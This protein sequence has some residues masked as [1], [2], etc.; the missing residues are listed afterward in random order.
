LE[1]QKKL[2]RFSGWGSVYQIFE[3]WKYY[4]KERKTWYEL[5]EELRKLLTEKEYNAAA[6]ATQN[7]HYTSP[8][9][10]KEMWTAL[11][12]FGFS[13]GRI[14]EPALGV[15]HFFGLMPEAAKSKL[16]GIELDRITGKVAKYLYPEANVYVQG[17]EDTAL[18]D[19]FFDIAISNVPF[20]DIQIADN[21]YPR[22]LTNKIHNYFFVKAL[23]KV[24]PGGLIM[25][26]TSTGTMDA[27]TNHDV[28]KYLAGKADFI[29]AV[30]LPG[31]TFRGIAKTD[32]T[33]DIIV[34]KKRAEGQGAVRGS[35]DR[36]QGKRSG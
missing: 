17:F 6:R 23:D 14:L 32:V 20:G 27:R 9:V 10:I 36:K 11:G 3:P 8:E 7:A 31:S 5:N 2:V 29:G 1:E 18:P 15:G 21:S 12:R 35:V 33:T 25:F 28:R 22:Y 16:V 4:D 19:N 26:I 13:G 30:R 34:L 24:R